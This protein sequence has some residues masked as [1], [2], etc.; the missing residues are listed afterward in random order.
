MEWRP[1]INQCVIGNFPLRQYS[2]FPLSRPSLSTKDTSQF[3]GLAPFRYDTT[4]GIPY[5]T[6]GY[7]EFYDQSYGS[8]SCKSNSDCVG[9]DGSNLGNC[10]KSVDSTS[11]ITA[12]CETDGTCICSVTTCSVNANCKAPDIC[13]NGVCNG[14]SSNCWTNVGQDIGTMILGK[15][16]F[17]YFDNGLTCHRTS[18]NFEIK[19]EDKG[20]DKGEGGQTINDFLVEAYENLRKISGNITKLSD[21]RYMLKKDLIYNNFAGNGINLYIINWKPDVK[22]ASYHET[23]FDA[24]EVSILYPGIVKKLGGGMKHISIS[25]TDINGDK[26]LKRIYLTLNSSNWILNSIINILD[27]NK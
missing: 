16:I 15:T 6:K 13:V 27:T 4:T 20:E 18:E 2:E 22:T 9:T 7:C 17:A 5:I 3:A 26:N 25:P 23:G 24:D 11:S 14:I 10:H 21:N 19:G 1:D 12:S 8:G